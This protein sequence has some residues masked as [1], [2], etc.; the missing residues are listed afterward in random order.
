MVNK[1]VRSL[2]KK[3]DESKNLVDF[4]PSLWKKQEPHLKRAIYKVKRELDVTNL[5][6]TIQKLK[7]GL[8]AV[9]QN[10]KNILERSKKLYQ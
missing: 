9:I 10:D 5:L 8:S 4:Q 7:A 2:Y 1:F 3:K 6:Q